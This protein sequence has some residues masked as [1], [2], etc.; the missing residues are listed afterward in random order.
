MYYIQ[1]RYE[2]AIIEVDADDLE[3]KEDLIFFLKASGKVCAIIPT[4]RIWLI[5]HNVPIILSSRSSNLCCRD[6]EVC[7][8]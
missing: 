6:E 4:E 2:D 7:H 5:R 8:G 3:L 1:Q